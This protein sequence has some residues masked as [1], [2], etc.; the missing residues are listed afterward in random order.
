MA[1]GGGRRRTAGRLRPSRLVR[2]RAF[3]RGSRRPRKSSSSPRT[4]LN[5]KQTSSTP[6]HAQAPCM[7]ACPLC[8]PRKAPRSRLA[9]CG[10]E[11]M[12]NP[13]TPNASESGITI[14]QT[15]P[16]IRPLLGLR[17]ERSQSASRVTDQRSVPCSRATRMATRTNCQIRPR[18]SVRIRAFAS[19]TC[20]GPLRWSASLGAT[21]QASAAMGSAA[22]AQM[23]RMVRRPY[24][25]ISI[26]PRSACDAAL[27]APLGYA[28]GVSIGS[29]LG[30]VGGARRR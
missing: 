21:S 26:S 16:P 27:T 18:V 5:R 3:I 9:A 24:W 10:R 8:V 20:A 28:R 15:R 13:S 29:F 11:G 4:V 2:T 14:S 25:G 23:V 1:C 6:Y 12:S 22:A 7:N 30:R 17:G 19:G